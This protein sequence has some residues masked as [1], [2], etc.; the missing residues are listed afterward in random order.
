M[1]NNK[2]TKT[3]IFNWFCHV[4]DWLI[5]CWRNKSIC[6]SVVTGFVSIY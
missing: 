1:Q 5:G 6:G 2:T 4:V 3:I